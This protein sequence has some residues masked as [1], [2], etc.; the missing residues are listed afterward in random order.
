MVI[1]VCAKGKTSAVRKEAKLRKPY[2]AIVSQYTPRKSVSARYQK[3][4][5]KTIL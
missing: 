4:P 2:P 1:A 5:V 3:L